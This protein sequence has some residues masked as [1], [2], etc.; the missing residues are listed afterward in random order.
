M[1]GKIIYWYLTHGGKKGFGGVPML[2]DDPPELTPK[3]I[4][5]P[6]S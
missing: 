3:T 4:P 1:W 5:P 2:S 6:A